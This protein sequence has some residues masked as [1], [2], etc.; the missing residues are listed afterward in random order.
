[1]AWNMYTNYNTL[2]YIIFIEFL[3]VRNCKRTGVTCFGCFSSV[4]CL[5]L[6]LNSGAA[7]IVLVTLPKHGSSNSSCVVH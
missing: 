4:F 6:L 7:D 5:K 1:M 2:S 3:R